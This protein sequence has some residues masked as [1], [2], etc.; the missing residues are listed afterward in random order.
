[1][2][3][4]SSEPDWYKVIL[5]GINQDGVAVGYAEMLLADFRFDNNQL[6]YISNTWTNIDLSALGYLTALVI[7]I[8]SSD[9]GS[10]GINTPA[11]VCI[12]NIEGI[13]LTPAE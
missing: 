12:D 1:M 7:K 6:D 10:Y 13:L 2:L 3:F 9:T 4:R 8:E 5:T 11:F